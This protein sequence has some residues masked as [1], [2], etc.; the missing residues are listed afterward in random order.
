MELNDLKFELL[1]YGP[2]QDIKDQTHYISPT[3]KVIKTTEA[4]KDFEYCSILWNLIAV[5]Q[6]QRLEE[7]Q[8]SF[9][10]KVNGANKN[11]WECL[12]EMKVFSL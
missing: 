9:L 5:G 1:R 3:G 4:V 12:K 10:R 2:N 7:V 8:R 11:Y 6:I